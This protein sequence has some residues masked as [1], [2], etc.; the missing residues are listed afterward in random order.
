MVIIKKNL[1]LSRDLNLRSPVLRN[2][3]LTLDN[4]DTYTNSDT[5][6][7]IMKKKHLCIEIKNKITLC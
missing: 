6:I 3:V 7:Y 4:W 1:C 2:G 5:N